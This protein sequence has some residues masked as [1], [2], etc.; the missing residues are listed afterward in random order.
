[1]VDLDERARAPAVIRARR[2]QAASSPLSSCMTPTQQAIW[3]LLL[4]STIAT[5]YVWIG[6]VA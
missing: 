3:M 4:V 6:P 1:M 2:Y 5:F